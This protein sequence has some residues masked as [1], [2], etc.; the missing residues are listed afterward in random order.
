MISLPAFCESYSDGVILSDKTK[1]ELTKQEVWEGGVMKIYSRC[2]RLIFEVTLVMICRNLTFYSR[3]SSM[4]EAAA[5]Y[6]CR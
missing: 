6:V 4:P 1:Q 5:A 2:G 3:I